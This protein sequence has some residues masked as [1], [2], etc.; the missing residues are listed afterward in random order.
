M[1]LEALRLAA[2]DNLW[3][4]IMPELMLGCIALLLL[5]LEIVLPRRL[6]GVIPDVAAAGLLGTL[7]G[8]ALN[9]S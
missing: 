6:H 8:L 4:A 3:G 5:G 1:T 2:A 9:W 7:L